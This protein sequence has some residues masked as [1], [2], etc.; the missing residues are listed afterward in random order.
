[1]LDSC[2]DCLFYRRELPGNVI[3]KRPVP[4]RPNEIVALDHFTFAGKEIRG[5]TH[6]LTLRDEFTRF[7]TAI[8][9]YTASHAEVIH[10]LQVYII[11]F[12]DLKSIVC[13]NFF[14]GKAM[15]DFCATSNIDLRHSVVYK[16][17]SNPFAERIHRSFRKLFPIMLEKS[18]IPINR[19]S[20]IVYLTCNIINQ[21]PCDSTGYP[22]CLLQK[23]YF[24]ST[25]F[26]FAGESS[27]L[28][29]VWKK[30]L[31]NSNRNRD[32]RLRPPSKNKGIAN[33]LE[34]GTEVYIFLGTESDKKV[35]AKVLLDM[36]VSVLVRKLEGR[37]D[38]FNEIVVH[39]SKIS[40][41]AKK[42]ETTLCIRTSYHLNF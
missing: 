22:P 42:L 19:W 37:K 20:E 17:S 3:A 6:I 32:K 4:R 39:K 33:R 14:R 8:P 21:T 10:Y 15:E 2:Q 9:V 28:E 5:Y 41:I 13:D 40:R 29:S 36:G 7:V 27:P 25:L 38:R 18:E 12:G 16:G 35:R 31:E 1:M 23:G 30:A 24:T 26:A 34:E 11:C